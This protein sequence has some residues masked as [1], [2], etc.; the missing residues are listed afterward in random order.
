MKY[1]AE[2]QAATANASKRQNCGYGMSDGELLSP[3]KLRTAVSKMIP[4]PEPSGDRQSLTSSTRSN[5][6]LLRLGCFRKPEDFS[7]APIEAREDSIG[8]IRLRC[9]QDEREEFA[10]RSF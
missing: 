1:G 10:P 2:G 8:I 9:K 3:A 4:M 6:Q 7:S 5:R